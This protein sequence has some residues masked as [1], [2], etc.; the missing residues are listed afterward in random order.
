M[1]RIFFRLLREP[2]R[3]LLHDRQYE[4]RF[5]RFEYLRSL[6]EADVTGDVQTVGRYGWRWKFA[7]EDVRKEIE[8]EERA[9]GR[10]WPPYQAG[11]FN[12]QRDRFMAAKK[13]VDEMIAGLRWH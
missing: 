5:D 10:K 2:F 12:G 3:V 8:A 13:K 6:L 4:R 7:E 9:G 11:W 1:N